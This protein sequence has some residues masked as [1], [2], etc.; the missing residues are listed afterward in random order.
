MCFACSY[1]SDMTVCKQFKSPL[2]DK[3]VKDQCAGQSVFLERKGAK[4]D[5]GD[6]GNPGSSDSVEIQ[7]LESKLDGEKF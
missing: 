6:K 7:N 4:G 1:G 2:D 3:T 5:K